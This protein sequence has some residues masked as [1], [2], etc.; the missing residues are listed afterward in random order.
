MSLW[1]VLWI[2]WG[3]LFFAIELPALLL[4]KDAEG[5][6]SAHVWAWFRVKD[7]RPTAFT[8]LLRAV[9]AVFLGWLSGHLLMGWWSL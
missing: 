8:W 6:L 1:T 5:T 9:L 4:T 2:V 7:Q 3:A